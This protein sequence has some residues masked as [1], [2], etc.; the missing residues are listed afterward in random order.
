MKY[1]DPAPK[2]GQNDS[3]LVM[4]PATLILTDFRAFYLEIL[5]FSDLRILEFRNLAV[6]LSF[7]YYLAAEYCS[8]LCWKWPE[9]GFPGGFI[10]R[11]RY[12][13]LIVKMV[14]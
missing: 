3:Q 12:G 11:Y 6:S 5:K 14:G 4:F 8:G 10:S 9:R 2:S 1:S 13:R 7:H